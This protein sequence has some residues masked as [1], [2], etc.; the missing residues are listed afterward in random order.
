MKCY[1]D[2]E[3]TGLSEEYCSLLEIAAIIVDDNFEIIDTFHQY[4]N[5][6]RKIPT[7]IVNLTRIT[8]EMVEDCPREN[9]IL[10]KF[11]TWLRGYGVDTIIAHNAKFD[12]KFLIGR[13][14]I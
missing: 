12:M 8:D 14:N 5:P 7:E 11:I 10:E 2:T 3:T 4:I 13:S 6:N 9:V 1:V